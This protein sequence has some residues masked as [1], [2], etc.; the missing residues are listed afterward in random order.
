MR[1]KYFLMISKRIRHNYD[2]GKIKEEFQKIL[3]KK[4]Q[5][6][7]SLTK[8]IRLVLNLTEK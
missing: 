7:I 3:E 1:S 4:R 5:E 2:I 6:H 8:K